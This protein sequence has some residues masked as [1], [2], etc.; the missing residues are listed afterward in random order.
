MEMRTWMFNST[1]QRFIEGAPI[2]VMAQVA[3][4]RS[5]GPSASGPNAAVANESNTSP[6]PACWP[7][8]NRRIEHL[9]RGGFEHPVPAMAG[10]SPQVVSY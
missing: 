4:E 7:G 5:M 10:T 8:K 2:C 1:L 3:L 6:A 9:E